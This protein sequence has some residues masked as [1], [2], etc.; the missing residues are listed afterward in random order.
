MSRQEWKDGFKRWAYFPRTKI[1][2]MTLRKLRSLKSRHVGN[3]SWPEFLE[4]L[5]RDIQLNPTIHEQVAEGTARTLLPV[6]MKNY[7]ENLPYIR[8]GDTV[9]IRKPEEYHQQTY[10]DLVESA[11]LLETDPEYA[12]ATGTIGEVQNTKI[13]NPPKGSA[14][15]VGRGPSLFKNKH[16]EL[17]AKSNYSGLIVTSD[18][19]L[20]PLLE[21]GVVPDVI[22]TVDGATII[23]K[24]FDHPLVK[25]HGSAMK[26]ILTVTAS[27]EVYLTAK[28]AGIQIYWFNP[29]FDDWRANESWTRLQVLMSRTDKYDRGV[30]RIQAG[31]NAGACAWI[32]AM[33]VFKRSPVALI[34]IDFGYPEGT[35]LENTQY[36]SNVLRISKGDPSI[37]KKAYPQFY[38]PIWQARAYCDLVFYHYRQAFLELQES[39]ELWYRLYGGTINCTEGGTLW[40]NDIKCMRFEEFLTK[41]KK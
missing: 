26:L 39:T 15:V 28:E 13:K 33:S 40:G 16:C 3:K 37:I 41:Y 7:A 4:Y 10:A 25:R 14:I 29:I 23:K 6:W 24:Y 38:H 36:Y 17:L 12:T 34:G 20:I 22:V 27:H 32:V 8:Y 11:P 19:G 1:S 35:K 31:G 5:V 21:A 30:P 9:N 2:Y 18:G